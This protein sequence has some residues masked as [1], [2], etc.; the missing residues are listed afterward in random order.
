MVC[1]CVSVG[2]SCNTLRVLLLCVSRCVT[3]HGT[4]VAFV[5]LQVC[6]TTRYICFFCLSEG[7]FYNSLHM[8]LLLLCGFVL[9]H[10]TYVASV[11]LWVCPTTRYICCFCCSVGLSYNTLHML[12][13]LLCGFVLQH[14]T[15][16]ASVA[17]WVCPTTHYMCCFSVSV[18]VSRDMLYLLCIMCDDLHTIIM[19]FCDSVDVYRWMLIV[20]DMCLCTRVLLSATRVVPVPAR[21]HIKCNE[22][23]YICPWD[24]LAC[25]IDVKQLTNNMF[26]L[27]PCGCVLPHATCVVSVLFTSPYLCS[28]QTGLF[29]DKAFELS[30]WQIS[31]LCVLHFCIS[32]ALCYKWQVLFFSQQLYVQN[33]VMLHAAWSVPLSQKQWCGACY[34]WCSCLLCCD[35]SYMWC[36]SVFC[37]VT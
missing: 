32:V 25:C 5:C 12:L 19:C 13:L 1:F 22:T 34:M 10:T 9:Q 26:F 15:Y 7:L 4:Y 24:T 2:M 29:Q 14:A 37:V 31:K 3:R 30:Y 27:C 11:A 35:V 16:V 6:P 20:S 17:L 28:P 21:L 23:H 8:F 36:S 33:T 18:G